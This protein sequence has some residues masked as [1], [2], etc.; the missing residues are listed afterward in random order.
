VQ[1]GR[2]KMKAVPNDI[3]PAFTTATA[4]TGAK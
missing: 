1:K 4:L 3:R 2:E